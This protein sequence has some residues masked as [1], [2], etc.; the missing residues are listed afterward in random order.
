MLTKWI[1]A[2]FKS[3]DEKVELDLAP[4]TLFVGPNSSG[5]ST[6]IQS[7]LLIAQTLS[8]RRSE[9][10]LLLNG[11]FVSLGVLGGLY[12]VHQS[13]QETRFR[14]KPYLEIGFEL[15]PLA[16]ET[17]LS[18][19][20]D[21]SPNSIKV[22]IRFQNR[23]VTTAYGDERDPTVVRIDLDVE[24]AS[25]E[26]EEEGITKK[27][28]SYLRVTERR[29]ADDIIETLINNGLLSLDQLSY[30]P[31][32][33]GGY[34]GALKSSHF[35]R[36][37]RISSEQTEHS[38]RARRQ[39]A[40]LTPVGT[41]FNRFL[42]NNMVVH[43]NEQEI[44]L[45][46]YF[47][48]FLSYIRMPRKDKPLSAAAQM[49]LVDIVNKYFSQIDRFKVTA[50]TL[51]GWIGHLKLK[52]RMRLH[53]KLFEKRDEWLQNRLI[54]SEPEYNARTVSIPEPFNIATDIV[55]NFFSH[56]IKY[57]GPLRAE[58]RLIYSLP[59]S[60]DPTDIG[61][62]G[63][64]TAAVLNSN[65]NVEVFYWDPA[66][67]D[68][69]KASLREAVGYWLHYLGIADSVQ[70]E[71]VSKLGHILAIEDHSIHQ[72][73]DLTNV[74]VGVSQLLPIL[75]SGLLA[76]KGSVLIY[77]QPEIHLHPKLQAEIADFFLGLIHCNKRCIVETHSEYLVNRLRLRLAESP[78]DDILS[79]VRILFTERIDSASRFREVSINKYGAITDWP[80][81]FFDQAHR[82]AQV[83]IEASMR[84]RSTDRHDRSSS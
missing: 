22:N 15:Q 74:G 27:L 67:K 59:L 11:E 13:S 8:S 19:I 66:I 50:D 56:N 16:E 42:P 54:E 52:D 18:K 81:G 20:I 72:F 83:L 41:Q 12:H 53:Y 31:Y 60:G 43:Y 84:K 68:V 77:E 4:L 70:T 28:H 24:S 9:P 80:Q 17:A 25:T 33:S 26:E 3:I 29:G 6:V 40:E 35:R 5:K 62:K 63:E 76:K 71:E 75:V 36:P 57:L 58:P 55:S 64:Y 78:D 73:L 30:R 2:N 79:K 49:E 38:V 39:T 46:N 82:E 34:A 14:K 7:I 69:V 10:Q 37:I 32:M 47:D 61:L 45:R 1:I 48:E 65:K 21:Y 23:Q 51:I 44:K